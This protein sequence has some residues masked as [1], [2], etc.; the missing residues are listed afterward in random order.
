MDDLYRGADRGLYEA[1]SGGATRPAALPTRPR[2][3]KRGGAPAAP[4]EGLRE[5]TRGPGRVKAQASS[6]R[7]RLRRFQ[8]ATLRSRRESSSTEYGLCSSSKP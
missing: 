8:L 5:P 7:M 2:A 1:K 4:G 3:R 6:P